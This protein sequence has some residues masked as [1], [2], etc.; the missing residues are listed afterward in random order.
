MIDQGQWDAWA[1]RRA[2]TGPMGPKGW[3]D[4]PYPMSEPMDVFDT[5]YAVHTPLGT[6]I[7]PYGSHRE[8]M[9][10]IVG[11]MM[12]VPNDP[13]HHDLPMQRFMQ[14]LRHRLGN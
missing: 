7:A 14:F 4:V 12:R 6:R 8:R 3:H 1:S 11:P 13:P 2:R 10:G 5:G 9:F